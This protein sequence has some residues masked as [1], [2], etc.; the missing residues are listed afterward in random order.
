[1]KRTGRRRSRAAAAALVSA[2]VLCVAAS[3]DQ[4]GIRLTGGIGRI[5]LNANRAS[6]G[7]GVAGP[8][9]TPEIGGR[10]QRVRFGDVVATLSL[11][12][13]KPGP[14]DRVIAVD[15]T[16]RRYRTFGGAG[17]GSTRARLVHAHPA[18]DCSSATFCSLGSFRPGR[19]VTTFR[20]RAGRVVSVQVGYVL[21]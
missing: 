6:L 19:V 1:M 2:L 8:I 13:A 18:V 14:A 21:D 7:L 16:A 5:S 11:E 9:R 3:A 15:T 4:P 12:G 17:V 10:L 20:L